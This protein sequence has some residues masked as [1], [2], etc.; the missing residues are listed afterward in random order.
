MASKATGT[1]IVRRQD[2]GRVVLYEHCRIDIKD[3]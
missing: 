1:A 3:G 2:G